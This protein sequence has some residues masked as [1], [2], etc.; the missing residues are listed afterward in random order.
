[1]NFICVLLPCFF[2][3]CCFFG[4]Q[5]GIILTDVVRPQGSEENLHF[6]PQ[7]HGRTLGNDN[8]YV[9][10][11]DHKYNIGNKTTMIVKYTIKEGPTSDPIENSALMHMFTNLTK[12]I[13]VMSY[14]KLKLM[15][16]TIHPDVIHLSIDSRDFHNEVNALRTAAGYN[17]SD[18]DFELFWRKPKNVAE[19]SGGTAVRGG[20]VQRF[21]YGFIRSTTTYKD[22]TFRTFQTKI[23]PHEFLH[24]FGIE[25][26]WHNRHRYG[27]DYDLLGGGGM[28]LHDFQ[29]GHVNAGTKHRF[30]WI[31]DDKIKDLPRNSSGTDEHIVTLKAFD[32]KNAL[33]QLGDSQFLGIRMET[34]FMNGVPCPPGERSWCPTADRDNNPWL[35]I[36][37]DNIYL[38]ISYRASCDRSTC[39]NGASLHLVKY[40][41]GD[42]AHATQSI[43]VRPITVEQRDMFLNPGETYVFEPQSDYSIKVKTLQ[44]DGETLR[45]SVKYMSG[46]RVSRVYEQD[47]AAILCEHTLGCGKTVRVD[48]NRNISAA[49][50]N[51]SLSLIKIGEEHK[52]SSVIAACS[53]QVPNLQ[54][55]VYDHFPHA[56]MLYGADVTIGAHSTLSDYCFS[57][58]GGA[59]PFFLLKDPGH[60]TLNGGEGDGEYSLVDYNYCDGGVK[61]CTIVNSET[62][63]KAIKTPHYVA[64]FHFSKTHIYM[65]RCNPGHDTFCEAEWLKKWNGNHPPSGWFWV[66]RAESMDDALFWGDSDVWVAPIPNENYTDVINLHSH[67]IRWY[68]PSYGVEVSESQWF[69][70]KFEIPTGQE[71]EIGQHKGRGWLI[72]K[73]DFSNPLISELKYTAHSCSIQECSAGS[74]AYEADSSSD[75]KSCASCPP[76]YDAMEGYEGSAGCFYNSKKLLVT[77]EGME[78]AGTNFSGIY[79]TIGEFMGTPVYQKRHTENLGDEHEGL[80]IRR[81]KVLNHWIFT[82]GTETGAQVSFNPANL[83]S[84]CKCPG[85][86][87]PIAPYPQLIPSLPCVPTSCLAD[88]KKSKWGTG[89][90]MLSTYKEYNISIVEYGEEGKGF[91]TDS[92]DNKCNCKRHTHAGSKEH[93]LSPTEIATETCVWGDSGANE[94]FTTT[95]ST[96]GP[97]A[98]TTTTKSTWLA[99]T[100]TKSAARATTTKSTWLATTTTKSA[101][102]ATTKAPVIT[103]RSPQSS[104]NKTEAGGHMD[105]NDNSSP[106]IVERLENAVIPAIV[107]TLVVLSICCAVYCCCKKDKSATKMGNR[108]QMKGNNK[109]INEESIV[110]YEGPARKKRVVELSSIAVAVVEH[111]AKPPTSLQKRVERRE[112]LSTIIKKRNP[113]FTEKSKL[114]RSSEITPES[115]EQWLEYIDEGSSIPYY[116]NPQT[117]ETQW[118]KPNCFR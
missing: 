116:Y 29:I 32:R 54:T 34:E 94:P 73:F 25:H 60:S 10:P 5:A 97:T 9:N 56:Q 4:A 66:M 83:K 96:T 86:Q 102:R 65:A 114:N 2:G 14:G 95:P 18:Y 53:V 17:Y 1:M 108:L 28:R 72:A 61:T 52:T 11:F 58:P 3:A 21:I 76:G 69:D 110:W 81:H 26:A 16:P 37:G 40:R 74:Y 24:N 15:P 44:A 23:L 111:S 27:D 109:E 100:T 20:R 68:T 38:Y 67:G 42:W 48:R 49:G 115:N 36:A 93:C 35:S 39:K 57:N 105:S 30:G 51:G 113:V 101:A 8:A 80:I 59:T 43:D 104:A 47:N 62:S 99:T 7:H 77:V 79:T 64:S 82:Y 98:S 71:I 84:T 6:A 103:T 107:G 19:G 91:V 75:C 112:R 78:P 70:A 55:Y 13:D 63:G 92:K 33:E 118:E 22:I 85:Y 31:P 41:E 45:V 90:K 89:S 46:K 106:S 12:F 88:A 117:Q 50:G 87:A